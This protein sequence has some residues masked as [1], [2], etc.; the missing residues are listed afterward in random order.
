MTEA[1]PYCSS[2]SGSASEVKEVLIRVPFM[3]L[4]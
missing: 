1:G 4:Q 2:I 3:K